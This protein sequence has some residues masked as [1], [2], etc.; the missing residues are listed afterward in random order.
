MGKRAFSTPSPSP[1]PSPSPNPNPNPN[2]NPDPHPTPNQA[3]ASSGLTRGT[4][5]TRP[6]CSEVC[7]Q[8]I[9]IASQRSLP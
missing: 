5:S 9:D 4:D 1:S 8:Y 7:T 2:P 3:S 6:S